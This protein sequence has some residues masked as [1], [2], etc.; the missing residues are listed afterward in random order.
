MQKIDSLHNQLI[1]EKED[2]VRVRLL[3]ELSGE[4]QYS[5]KDKALQYAN[6]ALELSTEI[7]FSEGRANSLNSIATVLCP[8][9][10]HSH[11]DGA[12]PVE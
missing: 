6:Q 8:C 9:C 5:D 4:N 3:N 12:I 7:Q 1:M 2:S 10:V 11:F